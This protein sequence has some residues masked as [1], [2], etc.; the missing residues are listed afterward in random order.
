LPPALGRV[1]EA[2]ADWNCCIS[3]SESLLASGLPPSGGAREKL[4]IVTCR[5]TDVLEERCEPERTNAEGPESFRA[6]PDP[7]GGLGA[8]APVESEPATEDGWS[9]RSVR[10]VEEDATARTSGWTEV[11]VAGRVRR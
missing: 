9:E 3:A 11:A 4:C 6:G 8:E 5:S 2:G 7:V 1:P 10:R